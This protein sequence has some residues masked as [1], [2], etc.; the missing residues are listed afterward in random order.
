MGKRNQIRPVQETD[1]PSSER[2]HH[3]LGSN[4]VGWK[5][6]DALQR[7]DSGGELSDPLEDMIEQSWKKSARKW[8]CF[9]SVLNPHS[10]AVRIWNRVF[11]LSLLCNTVVDPL[12]FYLLSVD[13]TLLCVYVQKAFAIT[14][15][16]LRTINDVLYLINMWL[17]FR[18]AYVS[19]SSLKLGIGALVTNPRKVAMNY[20]HILRGGL[21]LDI[22]AIL[23]CPQIAIW[24]LV[25]RLMT[26]GNTSRATTTLL[27]SLLF[28]FVIRLFR[29]FALVRRMQRVVGYIFWGSWW[30][31]VLNLAAY[32]AAAH[33]FGALWY[34]FAVSRVFSCLAHHCERY[35]GCIP[36]YLA[37]KPPIQFAKDPNISIGR[38][39]WSQNVNVTLECVQDQKTFHHGIYWNALPLVVGTSVA[40]KIA[41][42]IFWGLMTLSSFCNSLTPTDDLPETLFSLV[43]VMSGLMLFS[44][45]IGN[46]QVFFQSLWTRVDR[47]RAR[48]QDL[49][50]W[51]ARRQLPIPLQ[52][53]VDDYEQ[54]HWAATRGIDEE[55]MTRD[56]PEGLRRDIKRY[57]CLDLVRKIP[58]FSYTD[59]LLLDILCERLRPVLFTRGLVLMRDGE[60]VRRLLLLVRGRLRNV[61]TFGGRP[62]VALLGPGDFTGEE[63]LTWGL[64]RTADRNRLPLSTASLDCVDTVEAFALEADDLMY[65]TSHFQQRLQSKKLRHTIRHYSPHW[66]TWAAVTIQ[67]TWRRYKEAAASRRARAPAGLPGQLT[68]RSRSDDQTRDKLRMYTAMFTS[69]KPQDY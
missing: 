25:P 15:T 56:L 54:Q 13:T 44:A 19:K 9:D 30:G 6:Y 21:A 14:V 16:A 59:P 3:E 39:H 47:M 65:V 68:D 51:M 7:L 10:S 12:F 1:S 4:A 24:I 33:V 60:P 28:Q 8:F 35:P 48:R 52:E 31:F 41:F 23:P 64:S 36:H 61:H 26:S 55:A 57:L 46:I 49:E 58:L 43:L 37:C 5:V 20:V 29:Y 18:T 45:L 53:R 38:L 22:L 34:L 69:P 50:W 32:C 11:L 63:L 66:R 42:P 2:G 27:C 17:Q 40:E 62:S 67:L